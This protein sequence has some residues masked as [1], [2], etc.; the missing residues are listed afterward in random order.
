M[1]SAKA[2]VMLVFVMVFWTS[3]IVVAKTIGN[4]MGILEFSL[5]RWGI[6]ALFLFP[7]ALPRLMNRYSEIGRKGKEILYLGI[8]LAGGST[9]LVWSVQLTSVI[10]AALFSATQPI[11]TAGLLW[12]LFSEKVG[13]V[14]LLG[15]AIAFLGVFLIITNMDFKVL[16]TMSFNTG[17]LI[18]LVAVLLYSLYTIYL[19]QWCA[20]FSPIL[21][22]F[23]TSLAAAIILTLITLAT[24]GVP[25]R[26]F[27]LEVA[28]SLVYMALVPTAVATTMWN[29]A[30]RA[31]GPNKSSAFINLMPILGGLASVLVFDEPIGKHHLLGTLL[32]CIGL[33]FVLNGGQRRRRLESAENGGNPL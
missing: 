32:T 2:Y 6:A 19:N 31:V 26:S 11:L 14:Q 12:F 17:D 21:I 24:G 1:N 16:L 33:T 5:W 4:L 7:F 18:V 3:G 23:L 27:D 10:N 22:M 29:T 8:F 9:L 20:A 15:I 13:K 30:I 28:Q 25:F